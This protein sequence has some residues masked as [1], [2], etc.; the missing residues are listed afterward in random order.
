[1]AA[2]KSQ[3][4]FFAIVMG[5]AFNEMALEDPRLRYVKHTR[6]TLMRYFKQGTSSDLK[7]RA[8][9]AVN[10][11]IGHLERARQAEEV[12]K[13][14]QALESAFGM[15]GLAELVLQRC[16]DLRRED[17][18]VTREIQIEGVGNEETVKGVRRPAELDSSKK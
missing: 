17:C 15:I 14:P 16:K 11:L 10:R 6:D 5:M 7:E 13:N 4:R 9:D 12:K 3:E 18:E 8:I 2:L 1:M